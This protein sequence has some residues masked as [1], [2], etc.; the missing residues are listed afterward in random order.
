MSTAGFAVG[1]VSDADSARY[2]ESGDH[3]TGAVP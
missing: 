2:R 1:E 3:A